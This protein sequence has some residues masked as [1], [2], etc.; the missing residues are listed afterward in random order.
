LGHERVG[1]RGGK[2]A[3]VVVATQRLEEGPHPAFRLAEA[4]QQPI[5]LAVGKVCRQQVEVGVIGL[6]DRGAERLSA[7]K[8]LLAES[9]NA[10]SYAEREA[11]CRLRVEV[12]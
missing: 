7:F 2:E 1:W 8:T 5:E 4:A 12:P 6:F 10:R 9:C 11:G 3:D